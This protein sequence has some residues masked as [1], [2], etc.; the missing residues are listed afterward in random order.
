MRMSSGKG[1]SRYAQQGFPNKVLWGRYSFAQ[2]AAYGRRC[3]RQPAGSGAAL[4][5]IK[6]KDMLVAEDTREDMNRGLQLNEKFGVSPFKFGQQGSTHSHTSV[7]AI[8]EDNF[9]G[10]HTGFRCL[11]ERCTHGGWSAR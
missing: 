6:T 1:N 7:T 8:E 11:Q 2:D 4:S 3:L 10:K 5:E 9:F